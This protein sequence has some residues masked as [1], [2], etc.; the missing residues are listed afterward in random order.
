MRR[1]PLGAYTAP[2]MMVA[3]LGAPSRPARLDEDKRPAE[4]ASIIEDSSKANDAMGEFE[5]PD[6]WEYFDEMV[7]ERLQ[8]LWQGLLK[9]EQ[10][11]Y[12]WADV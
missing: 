5:V 11:R 3:L 1:L 7:Q 4:Y 10:K 8:N 9:G 6:D 12:R 2:R